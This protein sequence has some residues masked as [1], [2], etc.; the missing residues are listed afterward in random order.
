MKV[1]LCV[2][3]AITWIA[4]I[5][6]LLL[7][8]FVFDFIGIVKALIAIASLLLCGL[9]PGLM[10]FIIDTHEHIK[11]EEKYGVQYKMTNDGQVVRDT[12]LG[13]RILMCVI[14]A[15]FGIIATPFVF[16]SVLKGNYD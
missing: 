1:F 3:M 6:L 10:V 7:S 15:L 8:I 2:S 16:V 13:D 4:G 9:V 12:G 14:Y 11:E 5:V